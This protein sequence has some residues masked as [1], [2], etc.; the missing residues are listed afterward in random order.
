MLDVHVL[1]QTTR[2]LILVVTDWTAGLAVVLLHVLLK[3]AA[4]GIPCSTDL[5]YDSV[6]K[7]GQ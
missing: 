5:A 7:G 4:L 3:T 6:C 1:A 2:R